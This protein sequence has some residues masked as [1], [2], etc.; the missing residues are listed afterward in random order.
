MKSVVAPSARVRRVGALQAANLAALLFPGAAGAVGCRLLRDDPRLAW[1]DPTAGSPHFWIIAA[2][3]G[4][5]TA[6]GVGDWLFHLR[7]GRVVSPR[8]RRAEFFALGLGGAPLFVLMTCATLSERPGP[9]LVPAVAAALATVAA[10][11]YDELSF[12]KKCGRIETAYHRVLTLGM[13][14]AWLAWMHGCFVARAAGA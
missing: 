3:G 11:A 4:A 5:A 6:A 8:E 2:A 10:I 13:G 7:D 9:F 12:H 14:V 1:L